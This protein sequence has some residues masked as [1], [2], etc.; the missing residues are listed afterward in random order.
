MVAADETARLATLR[1]YA[2]LDTPPERAFD[3]LVLLASMLCS[4]PTAYVSFV[5]EGRP[6]IKAQYGGT[7]D[8]GPREVA[9][10]TRVIETQ[11]PVIVADAF[12][13]QRFADNPLVT[14]APG[15]RFYAGVP[16]LAPSG[17]ALGALAVL[18]FT[19]RTLSE[20][21]LAALC[22]LADHVMIQLELRRLVLG[23]LSHD[24][25]NLLT[26]IKFNASLLGAST[27]VPEAREWLGA[28]VEATNRSAEL[29]RNLFGA[30]RKQMT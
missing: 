26:V 21:N 16:L 8:E 30:L 28:I 27:N 17:H 15:I 24:V 4:A 10:C 23:G 1:G 11:A 3:D 29:V 5:G 14:G 18:D 22:V 2:V 13:D 25:N 9:F 12:A 6:W 20:S 19:P 7:V